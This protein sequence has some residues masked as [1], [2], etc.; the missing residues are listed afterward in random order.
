M[1]RARC[2][3]VDRMSSVPEAGESQGSEPGL[4]ASMLDVRIVETSTGPLVLLAGDLD[5]ECAVGF[6]EA[7]ADTLTANRGR[8][9]HLDLSGLT[10]LDVAG[11]RAL[12]AV[13]DRVVSEGGRVTVRGL[14]ES[15]VPV[16]A[17]LGLRE[18][19]QAGT[20]GGDDSG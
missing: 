13:R 5:L 17:V 3:V 20:A 18:F 6:Q 11:A 9:V 7:L 1:V 15:R 16:A 14:D 4:S 8:E 12:V 2:R 19:L 10:F